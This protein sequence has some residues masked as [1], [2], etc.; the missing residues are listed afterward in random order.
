M[1]TF[2]VDGVLSLLVHRITVDGPTQPLI[3][4]VLGVK[5]TGCEADH[6]PPSSTEVKN[7][8]NYTSTP[9][10]IFMVWC[11]ITQGDNC[12]YLI[13]MATVW[14]L[15]TACLEGHHQIFKNHIDDKTS[16]HV[17]SLCM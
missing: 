11:F 5:Q 17:Q 3:L 6:S 8:W 14:L 7:A 15:H 13:H 12:F 1:N 2:C 16:K 4:W 9:S 10:Y